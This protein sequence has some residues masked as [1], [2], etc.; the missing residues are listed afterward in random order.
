MGFDPILFL[1]LS[2]SLLEE[3]LDA[4]AKWVDVV[5]DILH[6]WLVISD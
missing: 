3:P 5:F 6:V 4:V 2:W 1:F